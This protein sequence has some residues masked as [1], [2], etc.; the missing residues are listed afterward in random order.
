MTNAQKTAAAKAHQP[1][2]EGRLTIA[3]ANLETANEQRRA[4]LVL[5]N[6]KMPTWNPWRTAWP[7]RSMRRKIPDRLSR[8]GMRVI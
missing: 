7:S 1:R 2:L 6:R 4:G 3:L 5:L 8:S